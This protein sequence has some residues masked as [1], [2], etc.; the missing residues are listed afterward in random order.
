[1]RLLNRKILIIAIML[2]TSVSFYSYASTYNIE[3]Q[4]VS[5]IEK[6]APNESTSIVRNEHPRQD[7]LWIQYYP[8]NTALRKNFV[9]SDVITPDSEWEDFAGNPVETHESENETPE[10]YDDSH[11]HYQNLLSEVLNFKENSNAVSIWGDSYAVADKS[12]AWGGFF[13]ARSGQS[14][15]MPGQPFNEYVP[16]NYQMTSEANEYDTQL[17]GVEIDVLNDGLPGV[18]PNMS[19]T[20]LQIVGFGNPNSM[21]IEVRCEDTDKSDVLPNE[22]RG[23][24][25]T[26]IYFKNSLA[27]YGRVL[28]TDFEQAKI[29][30]DFRNTLFTEGAFDFKTQ[31]VGTGII[32]NNGNSGEIYGGQRWEGTDDP[33]DWLTLRAGNGGIRIVSQDNTKELVAVDNYGGIYLNGDVYLNGQKLN[34]SNS[35]YFITIIAFLSMAIIYLLYKTRT[36]TNKV[37]SILNMSN[38]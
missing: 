25:E 2:I 35:K 8:L 7:N 13:S 31:Q 3:S 18:F 15:F 36:L 20:G 24:W 28:V 26:G 21:A 33:N 1:M 22:R 34:P 23:V 27:P 11:N 12:K 38:L 14:L 16:E 19:K 30:L 10:N 9:I 6:I 32:L 29:G 37:N 17:T 4:S 5:D